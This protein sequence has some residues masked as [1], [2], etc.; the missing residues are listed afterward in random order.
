MSYTRL[1]KSI[2]LS[3]FPP[4]VQPEDALVIDGFEPWNIEALLI[5]REKSV[6]NKW[7]PSAQ[8]LK[9]KGHSFLTAEER[10]FWHSFLTAAKGP[11][12]VPNDTVAD[13]EDSVLKVVLKAFEQAKPDLEVLK[14]AVDKAEQSLVSRFYDIGFFANKGPLRITTLPDWVRGAVIVNTKAKTWDIQCVGMNN[15]GFSPNLVHWTA[16]FLQKES[17]QPWMGNRWRMRATGLPDLRM[18]HYAVNGL[19]AITALAKKAEKK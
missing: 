9:T 10:A 8:T 2:K 6:D 5:A 11:L 13:V 16:S 4:D 17:N 19:H 3:A 7:L 14:E 1:M 12:P 15:A 18:A